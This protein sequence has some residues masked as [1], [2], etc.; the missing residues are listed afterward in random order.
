M[1]KQCLEAYLTDHHNKLTG[2]DISEAV[3]IDKTIDEIMHIYNCLSNRL[4]HY[5]HSNEYGTMP[6]INIEKVSSVKKFC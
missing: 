6:A 2:Y 3:V 1:L 4:L 5:R